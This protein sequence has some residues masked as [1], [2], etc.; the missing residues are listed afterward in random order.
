MQ[1]LLTPYLAR[2]EDEAE[3]VEVVKVVKVP[4]GLTPLSQ[5][6]QVVV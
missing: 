2:T 1:A 4:M 5:L 6:H 3:A